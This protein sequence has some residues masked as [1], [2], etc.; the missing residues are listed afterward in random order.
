[1]LRNIR[2]IVN[3]DD[4]GHAQ[5][6]NRGIEACYRQGILTSA[7][8][9]VNRP[10]TPQGVGVARS[11]SGLSVGLHVNVTDEDPE[12][13]DLDDTAWVE[14]ELHAQYDAFLN[15]MGR[16]PT[17]LDSHHHIHWNSSLTD[18]FRR[19]AAGKDL[20]LR[21]YSGVGYEGGFYG[22]WEHGVTDLTHVRS[23]YLGE[24]LGSLRPGVFEVACHPVFVTP[25]LLSIYSAEREEEVRTLIGDAARKHVRALGIE[26][27][28]FAHYRG[29]DAAVAVGSLPGKQEV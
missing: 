10:A 2:V 14:R 12:A 23:D 3:A 6:I 20:P 25:D 18:L 9:M 28:S 11:N 22:Q 5:G 7:S 17:H 8:L 29:S 1:M 16:P 27:I 21:H 19:F 26:L 13:V 24:L 15:L 4:L